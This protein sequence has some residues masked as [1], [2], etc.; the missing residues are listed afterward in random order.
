M[1]GFP[2]I[3]GT[4]HT[5]TFSFDRLSALRSTVTGGF[6]GTESIAPEIN[7]F[8]SYVNITDA[9][10]TLQSGTDST[11]LFI[12]YDRSLITETFTASLNEQDVSSLFTPV[13]GKYEMVNI[14]VQAGQNL[15]VLS[16]SGFTD[17]AVETDIDSL[18]FI[19]E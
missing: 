17:Y 2:Y 3:P 9:T 16:I 11:N 1:T 19:V 13:E 8:L 12:I 4:V 6:D 5:Y 14:P 15:L 18:V 7:R 10:T